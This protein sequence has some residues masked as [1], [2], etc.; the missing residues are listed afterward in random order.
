MIKKKQDVL[1]DSVPRKTLAKEVADRIIQ[2]LVSGHLKPG[3]KLYP[4]TELTKMLAVSRPV[5]REAMSSLESLG[6]IHRKTRDGTYFSEKIGSKPYTNMLSLAGDDLP[7]IIEARMALELG[8]VTLAAEKISDQQLDELYKTIQALSEHPGDYSELDKEFHRIIAFSVNNYVLEGMIDSLL[9][10]FDRMSKKIEFRER[11]VAVEHHTA[12]YEALK[13]R[14]PSEAV[15]QM[16]RHL[17]YV[18]QK[19][20]KTRKGS[21]D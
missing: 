11:D 21:E 10:A 20:L 8:M 2:L 1:L 19:I 6:I 4:E 15:A 7:S 9:M 12:I 13:K 17:D 5:L 14:S 16:Y 18:R 3:D